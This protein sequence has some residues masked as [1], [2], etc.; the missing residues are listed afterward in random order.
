M[1]NSSYNP[2]VQP[3]SMVFNNNI[4]T[5]MVTHASQGISF[6]VPD[7]QPNFQPLQSIHQPP[8]GVVS[9]HVTAS[10][11]VLDHH[12]NGLQGQTYPNLPDLQ[13]IIGTGNQHNNAVSLQPYIPHLN[14]PPVYPNTSPFNVSGL[15]SYSPDYDLFNVGS[16]TVN[17]KIDISTR[18]YYLNL[19]KPIPGSTVGPLSSINMDDYDRNF[20]Y[21]LMREL[22]CAQKKIEFKSFYEKIIYPR[23]RDMLIVDQEKFNILKGIFVNHVD[24]EIVSLKSDYTYLEVGI[25]Y[26][27][28]S[29][30]IKENFENGK[31]FFPDI[32]SKIPKDDFPK[33]KSFFKF[34]RG[35]ISNTDIVPS[36]N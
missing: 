34:I 13:P 33:M 35:H 12:P 16:N 6:I 32:Y 5:S 27:L 4:G 2:Q 18:L 1:H 21:T 22:V 9:Q 28:I 8:S 11:Q 31:P 25:Y 36:Y 10:V 19:I 29:N 24:L 26:N 7:Q 17:F 20:L 3:M 14:Y 15:L 30:M 23:T